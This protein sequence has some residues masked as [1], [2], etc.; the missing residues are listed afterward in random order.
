MAMKLTEEE[1]PWVIAGIGAI[2]GL[3]AAHFHQ[4]G[5]QTRLILKDNNAL[6]QYKASSLSILSQREAIT[7]QPEAID[8]EH[9]APTPIKNLISCVKAYD[10]APLLQRLKSHLNEDSRI[11]LIHNGLG[12]V[13]EIKAQR[14]DLRIVSGISTLGA[15]K[16]KPFRIKA[17][18]EGCLTLGASLG[19]FNDKDIKEICA[20]FAKSGLPYQWTD[21]IHDLAWEKF[22]IN[23]SINVLTVMFNCRNAGLLAHKEPLRR[24]T[25]EIAQVLAAYGLRLSADDLLS[26]VIDVID[27]TGDN[28]SSMYKDVQ[29]CRPTELPYLNERLIQ[30]AGQ[31]NMDLPFNREMVKRFHDAFPAKSSD[32]CLS[33]GSGSSS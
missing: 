20:A 27:M 9:I 1:S 3:L 15:Y 30:L 14:R 33:W 26:S 31:K 23:C 4:S 10:T 6:K 11:I 32:G 25:F 29:C 17:F 19:H 7:C 8:L 24:M 16:E 21:N 13:E 5:L 22:A 28:Y 12:V 18:L 2:G